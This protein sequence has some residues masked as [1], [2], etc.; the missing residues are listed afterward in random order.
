MQE[1]EADAAQFQAV[2]SRIDELTAKAIGDL[3]IR[4]D[5]LSAAIRLSE[6]REGIQLACKLAGVRINP[7]VT[8]T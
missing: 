3:S 4:R 7:H 6:I 2:I 8:V 5:P 1:L